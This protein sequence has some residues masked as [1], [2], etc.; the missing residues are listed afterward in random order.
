MKRFFTLFLFAIILGNYAMAYDF[1][2]VCSS[3]QTLY[4]NITSA[5]E[6]YTV[7]VVSENTSSP[8]YTNN[9][10]GDLVIPES[11]EYNSITYSVTSIGGCAFYGCGGLTLVTIPNSI[12]SIGNY[13]FYN[14]S[15]LISLTIGNS[16]T[17][18]GDYAFSSCTGLTAV[19]IP[20]SVTI[21]GGRAFMNCSGLTSV[22]IP[23][24]VMSIGT[25]AFNNC[26]GLTEPIYNANSF[27][28]FPCGY[29]TEY[30]IPDGIQQIAGGAF[31]NCS[32]LT[33]VTI[34]NS[35]TSIG[36]GAFSGCSGLTSVAIPDSVT[37]IGGRAFSGCSGL[38]GTLTIPNSV[39]D[40]GDFAFWGC[41]ELTGVTIGYSVTSIGELAFRDCSRLTEVNFN[42]TNCTGIITNYL[43]DTNNVISKITI[44]E[45]VTIVPNNAFKYCSSVDSVIS[46]ATTPPI[47]YGSTFDGVSP[48]IPVIVPCGTVS[49]Y[50]TI[51]SYFINIQQDASC[52]VFYTIT[53]IPNNPY[54]G[55]VSGGG[56]YLENTT[57]MLTAIPA[58]GYRFESWSDGSTENPYN[59]VV[60]AD[61]TYVA[62]FVADV[63]PTIY[64]EITAS[65][66][67]NYT[68]NGIVYTESGD[69]IQTF[70][71]ENSADSIVTLH[72]TV[73]SLPQPEITV[74]GILDACNPETTSV[75]LSAGDYSEFI[76]SNGE[77][78]SSI[79][80]TSAG[81][82]FVEVVDE[83]GCHG[84]SEETSVGY[85]TILTEAPQIKG[86]GIS[87]NGGVVIEWRVTS[88]EGIAGFE[89]YRE[90]NV[91]N[92]YTCVKRIER[93]G[94]RS[95]ID[96]TANPSARAYRY[97]ICAIDE[98]GG[99]SPMSAPHKS[100]HLTINRGIG[101]NWNL[102][103]SPYEGMDFPSYKIYRGT[104]LQDMIVIGEV[105]SNL[106][107]FT[108]SDNP[109]NVGFFYQVEV[110]RNSKTRD[111]EDEEEVSILSNIV[112]N[113]YFPQHTIIAVSYNPMQ[114]TVTGGGIYPEG[115]LV[116]LTAEAFEGYTF[117]SWN[118]GSTDNPRE[119]AVISD[120]LYV[121]SFIPTNSIE[122]NSAQEISI[123]PNPATDILNITSSETIS[124]IEIVNALG[125]V[126]YRIE[127]NADN[128]VCDVNGLANGV[129]VVRIH[130]TDTALVCQR[131]FIK[132]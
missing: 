56:E 91:A 33:S 84:Y 126:V 77:T 15:G 102:I 26:S 88:T 10:E 49:E 71:A 8:Y 110:V 42:P 58:N 4:Y 28:Y 52:P 95:C 87:R 31:D 54:F 13:A 67:G 109:N 25:L 39:T 53:A 129:Y 57:A 24:S 55:A 22:T 106:N 75:T 18:I 72:L 59:V 45:N 68:W 115:Y 47:I 80:V 69:H 114:G 3:G 65:S 79:V 21:I 32:E 60:T 101:D 94:V 86:I 30:I 127:V 81:N 118:D 111:G 23:N 41:S 63:Y 50:E 61:A 70:T 44:G 17:S 108:D 27:A 16:V 119:I 99:M 122:E 19:T 74:D 78:S 132:E 85:S 97:K 5:V 35:I 112:D 93:P 6:P 96:Q 98:C 34:P 117:V 82:Y 125:Q 51:W 105:S 121:A 124:E 123:F 48:V 92:T 40:I 29:A 83:H 37:S 66:C 20:N 120:A 130:G 100:V 2:A 43:F 76:W 14:C 11:V 12:T 107:S 64:T 7:E 90:D 36:N 1:S 116:T 9:P 46:L 89:I 131:K 73:H 104:S 103:W 113:G 128:A 38:T 62:T